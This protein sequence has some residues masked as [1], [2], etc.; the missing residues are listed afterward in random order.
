MNLGNWQLD[1]VS[2]GTFRLDGGTMFGV[3]PKPLWEKVQPADERNRIRMATNCVLARDGRHTVLVDTG[4]G[5]KLTER[6]WDIYAA[7]PGEPLLESLAAIGVSPDDVDLVVLS[8]L[9]FDHAGGGT[10]RQAA[11]KGRNNRI[12]PTFPRARYVVQ[13]GEWDDATSGAPELEGAYPPEN[14]LPLAEA[15][16][17]ERIDGDVEIVPGLRSMLTPGHTRRHQSLVFSSAGR[18]AIYLGDLCPMAAHVRRMWCIAYDIDLLETRRRK[19]QVLGQA[20]DEN[21]IVL[22]DHDPDRTANRLVRDAK[23]EF[24]VVDV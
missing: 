20:A 24:A 22:W 18:T 14:F 2:G 21:W 13:S 5:G 1:V 7:Q 12:V 17:L 23:K 9:H 11:G 8:H 3:V 16:Q 19:P 10:R 6:E 4:Y 15:G